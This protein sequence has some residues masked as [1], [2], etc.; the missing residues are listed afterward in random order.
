MK[1]TKFSRK[2]D[3]TGVHLHWRKIQSS[4]LWELWIA[5]ITERLINVEQM[6]CDDTYLLMAINHIVKNWKGMVPQ[7][8]EKV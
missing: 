6:K 4:G 8:E 1:P 7:V 5:D 2:L 3:V